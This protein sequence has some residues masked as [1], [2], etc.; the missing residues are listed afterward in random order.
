M[1]SS[2]AAGFLPCVNPSKHAGEDRNCSVWPA[3]DTE[4]FRLAAR[5]PIPIATS[6]LIQVPSI[7]AWLPPQKDVGIVT[8]DG[9]QLTHTHFAQL[10]IPNQQ[11]HRLH[12]AG[13]PRHGALQQLVREGAS[14]DR[15]VI[16]MELVSVAK[17]LVE[18]HPNIGAIVL[19]CTQMPPFA[20]AI[21]QKLGIPVYDVYTMGRWFYEGLI[22]HRPTWETTPST[23]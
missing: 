21:H 12:I 14:Y 1:E 4:P 19:E 8:F 18:Q 11:H 17:A 20:G 22:A 9:S 10:G 5:L 7:I 13:P 23:A 2:P 16:E 15:P 3:A 6:S